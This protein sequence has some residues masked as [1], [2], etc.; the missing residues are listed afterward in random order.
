MIRRPP[1][2]T[3]FPYTTL[4]RSLDF[5]GVQLRCGLRR[6]EDGYDGDHAALLWAFSRRRLTSSHWMFWKK[7]STYLAAADRKSTRL[8]SSH[9]YIS[10]AVFCLKK[11]KNATSHLIRAGRKMTSLQHAPAL[12]KTSRA[13]ALAPDLT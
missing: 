2:S 1:R 8:N 5:G 12:A 9:G 3:L 4:F 6:H 7:A 10:Y 13:P 11:K